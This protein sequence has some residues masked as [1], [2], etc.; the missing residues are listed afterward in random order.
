MTNAAMLIRRA[1]DDVGVTQPALAEATGI[2]QPR[3]S[4][5][6]NGRVIPTP[7]TLA[8]ILRALQVRPSIR[9]EVAQDDVVEAVHCFRA[10]AVWVFGSCADGSDTATSNVDLLVEFEPEAST[11]DLANLTESL[12][13]I[14]DVDVDV[15]SA[16]TPTA[17][18]LLTHAVKL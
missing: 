2:Q 11:Y 14:L 3:L 9:L 4:Q 8:R 16:G 5:Y 13:D 18:R 1:R 12:R 6:E 17:E 15:V 10:R 7:E